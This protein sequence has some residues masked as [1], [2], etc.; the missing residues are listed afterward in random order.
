[1]LEVY[2]WE[3]NAASGRVLICLHEKHLAFA[4][5]YVDLLGFE[6][7][8]AEFLRLNS[9]GEVPVLVHDGTAFTQA[10]YI[11]EYLEEL[12]AG[13]PLMPQAARGRWQVR[14][15]QK[16]VDDCI[17]PS[18][19]E[20]AWQAFGA[21]LLRDRDPREVEQA[22]NAIPARERRDQWRA[23]AD[24]YGEDVLA[25]ARGRVAA[26]LNKAEA[27]LRLGDW[28]AGS[29]YS[30][31]DIAAFSYLNYLPRLLPGHCS[32]RTTPRVAA[33]LRRVAA[34]PAA[35]AALAMGRQ[36]DPYALAAPGP[37]QVR[38]G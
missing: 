26:A 4:A 36:P 2:H 38:W 7:H 17:A 5:R 13:P 3:P 31:A 25:R 15:W 18:V 11:C 33:W 22:I 16:Y 6:Q 34:R 29:S 8:R 1:M 10:S 12:A 28:L 9:T 30:L 35:K 14:L 19:G 32:E 23:A 20:L 24:G 27:D 37:E 21:S